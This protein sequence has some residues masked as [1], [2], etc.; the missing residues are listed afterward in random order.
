[1]RQVKSARETDLERER[2]GGSVREIRRFRNPPRERR[3]GFLHHVTPL[4]KLEGRIHHLSELDV[5]YFFFFFKNVKIA[6]FLW[7]PEHGRVVSQ[8]HVTEE[9]KT[10][11]SP[12]SLVFLILLT[13]FLYFSNLFCSQK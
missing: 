8:L 5:L 10:K 4:K 6:S 13:F 11:F 1:M 12:K 9:I 7:C 2:K 3:G